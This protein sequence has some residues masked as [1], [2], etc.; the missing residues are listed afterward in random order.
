[1]SDTD[2]EFAKWLRQKAAEAGFPIDVR[3]SISRLA[4]VAGTDVGQTSRALHGKAVPAPDTLRLLAR[5]LNVHVI[6][7]YIQAG[8]LRGEDVNLA[9]RPAT[10]DDFGK[11][12]APGP[13]LREALKARGRAIGVPPEVLHLYVRVVER[14]AQAIADELKASG[15]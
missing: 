6:E 10:P 9:I 4:Q 2:T 11:Y 14:T 8:V 1:M 5:A 3:G 7:M 12:Q 13:D 15:D